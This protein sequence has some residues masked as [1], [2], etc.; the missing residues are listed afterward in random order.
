VFK[1]FYKDD[2]KI[3]VSQFTMWDFSSYFCCLPFKVNRALQIQLNHVAL[4][5][6]TLINILWMAF[7]IF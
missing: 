2:G 1:I 3:V 5:G 6:Y 4:V 7:Y